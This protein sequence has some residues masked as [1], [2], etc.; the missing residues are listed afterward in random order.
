MNKVELQA[1]ADALTDQL[2]FL[3]TLYEMVIPFLLCQAPEPSCLHLPKRAS[4]AEV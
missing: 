3:R 1:Q 2:S 4:Q